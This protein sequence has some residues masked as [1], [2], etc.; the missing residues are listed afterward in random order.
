MSTMKVLP[1]KRRQYENALANS[2]L[3]EET[4]LLSAKSIQV[5]RVTWKQKVVQ[6]GVRFRC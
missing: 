6:H 4:L 5:D 1:L 3:R 2:L